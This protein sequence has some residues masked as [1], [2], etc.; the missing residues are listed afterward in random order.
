MTSKTVYMDMQGKWF[1]WF[2]RHLWI[3]GSEIKAI[4]MWQSAFPELCSIEHMKEMFLPIVSGKKK[5]TGKASDE[6]GFGFQDDNKKFW[7]PDQSGKENKSFPLIDSWEDVIL[8]KKVKLYIAELEL[9][10]FKMNRISPATFSEC[11]NSIQWISSTDENKQE[12]KIRQQINT[13]W[14]EIRNITFQS[15]LN[16][17]LELLPTEPIPLQTGPT[18]VTKKDR[19]TINEVTAAYNTIISTIEPI[20]KYFQDKYGKK[21]FIYSESKINEICEI[22]YYS[23]ETSVE[24]ERQKTKPNYSDVVSTLNKAYHLD[25]ETKKIDA[26]TIAAH[27]AQQMASLAGFDINVDK[28]IDNMLNEGKRNRVKPEDPKTTKFT[29]GYIDRDGK[30]YTCCDIDHRS[31]SEELCE[32]FNFKIK[33]DEDAQITL[34]KKGWVKISMNRFFWL[35]ERKLTDQQKSTIFDYMSGKKIEKALFNTSLPEYEKSL[36]EGL[37]E[38]E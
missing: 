37:G 1:T 20:K 38:N 9:R 35:I 25:L 32:H 28:Y 15:G 14:T 31:F 4:R 19:K 13:Y 34:D 17:T 11:N 24:D 2:L 16:L 18:G 22:P 10:S 36:A 27:T 33:K 8:L 23:K 3:E 30:L 6:Q 5:F 7:D 12:N 26:A 21:I 29:S